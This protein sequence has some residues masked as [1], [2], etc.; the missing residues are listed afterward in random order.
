VIES[1]IYW[2][3]ILCIPAGLVVYASG[4][5]YDL[6]PREYP[7]TKNFGPNWKNPIIII[8][9]LISMIPI[10]N[11]YTIGGFISISYKDWRSK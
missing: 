9:S 6:F 4:I 10:I 2:Y 7:D 1:I 11:L 5:Y 8:Y 3:L